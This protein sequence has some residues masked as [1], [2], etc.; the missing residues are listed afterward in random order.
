MSKIHDIFMQGLIDGD[1]KL[2]IVAGRINGA[3]VNY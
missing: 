2:I 3:R 1:H